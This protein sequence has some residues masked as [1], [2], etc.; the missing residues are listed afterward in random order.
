MDIRLLD[1]SAVIGLC[2]A[3]ALT[4]N[5]LLGM[6]LS[7][8]Y[9]RST[10]WKELPD[11]IKKLHMVDVHNWTAY[12][13][14]SLVFFHVLFLL[15]DSSTKFTLANALW[16]VNAPHQK[17]EVAFGTIA[18]YALITVIITTQKVVKKKMS[19]RLW[20]NI[21]LISYGTALL[22]I[23]HG[24]LLDPNLK[25]QPVDWLD[26]EKLVPEICGLIL[27]AASVIRYR[28]HVKRKC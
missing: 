3:C 11:K 8:A 26:G 4:F 5:I 22:F 17:L 24:I 16:P 1:V 14:L 10:L 19:F 25:D 18:L 9:K 2:A 27:V 12:V 7:T 13:A 20:K 21:H 6:M 15:L 28:Y 23:I